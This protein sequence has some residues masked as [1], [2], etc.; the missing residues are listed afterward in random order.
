MYAPRGFRRDELGDVE[1]LPHEGRLH[2]FHLTLPNHDRVAHLVS[3]D[4]LRWERRPDAL[5]TGPPGAFDDDMIWTVSVTRVGHRFHMLYTA[6]GSADVGRVQ[7]LG[8]AVSD[9]LEQ[10]TKSDGPISEPEP[11]YETESGRAP[12]ASWRDPKPVPHD[13]G[14]ATAVCARIGDGPARRAGAVALLSSDDLRHMRVHPPLF[15]PRRHYELECPQLFT[16]DGRWVLTASVMDDRSQRYW[17]ADRPEGPWR[18]PP[19]NRLLPPGHYAARVFRWRNQD[20]IL[21]WF[22]DRSGRGVVPSPMRLAL[23]PDRRLRCAPWPAWRAYEAE[24]AQGWT[25]LDPQ[26]GNPG[27]DRRDHALSCEAGLELWAT[28]RRWGDAL[29]RAELRDSAG[30]CGLAFG[31]DDEGNGWFVELDRGEGRARLVRQGP[32]LDDDGRPWFTHEVAQEVAWTAAAERI[33][34]ALRIVDDE[35]EL[36]IDGRVVLSAIV[37]ETAGRLGAFV[38]SGRLELYEA[39]IT[40]MRRP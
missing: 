37:T 15:A 3:D 12:W 19:A 31:L 26:L 23:D 14:F 16:I 40:A 27:A 32:G 22:R 6:L 33:R 11:P 4:G 36:A 28:R 18:T 24:P 20:A 34:L 9:D 8:L 13:T 35:V 39:E 10:W 5:R 29:V 17:T 21:G 38:D 25:E 1:V 2:L 7:R 30:L